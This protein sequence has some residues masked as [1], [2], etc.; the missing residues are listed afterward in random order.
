M[1]TKTVELAEDSDRRSN[2]NEAV[3]EGLQILEE[4]EEEERAKVAWLEAAIQEGRDDLDRGDY[5]T[6][7]GPDEI[8]AFTRQ[9]LRE[10]IAETRRE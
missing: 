10:A 1:P 9:A 6:L 2:A 7:R 8:R 3:T 4:G 5:I